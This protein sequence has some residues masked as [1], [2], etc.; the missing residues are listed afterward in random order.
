LFFFGAGAADVATAWMETPGT[1]G[2]YLAWGLFS[3]NSWCWAIFMLYV[4]MRWLDSRNRWLEYGQDAAMP[5]YLFHQPVIIVI[6]FYVVQWDA[7]AV[8]GAGASI[9]IKLLIV[10][11]SSFVVTL[12]LYELLVR[13]IK[14][15]RVL[16]GIKLGKTQA[17]AQPES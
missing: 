3:A 5:F 12:G 8:L 16:F 11:S 17:G 15:V 9:L 4:G 1:A 13:R 6:A 10:V 7:L 2:F 14:P